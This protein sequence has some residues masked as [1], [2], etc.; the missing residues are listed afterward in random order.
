MLATDAYGG[1]WVRTKGG[2]RVHKATCRYAAT[3]APWEWADDLTLRGMGEKMAD[4]G[5]GWWGAHWLR[6]CHVCLSDDEVDWGL[7]P[8]RG[9]DDTP[10]RRGT[11]TE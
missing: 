10:A 5:L 8:M 9:G 2:L 4:Q 3:G 11:V 7:R 6:L 1:P